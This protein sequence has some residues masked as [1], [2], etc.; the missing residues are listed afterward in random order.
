MTSWGSAEVIKRDDGEVVVAKADPVI[1]I[2][3]ELWQQLQPPHR[4]DDLTVQLDTAGQYV[5]RRIGFDL[6]GTVHVCERIKEE[7]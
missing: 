7:Q 4:R 3:D 6:G 2:H 5:Y 1:G